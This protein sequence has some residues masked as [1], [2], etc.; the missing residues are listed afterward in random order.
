MSLTA[1]DRLQACHEEL[2]GA[3][4]GHDVEAIQASVARFSE[5]VQEVRALGGWRD[6]PDVK[7]RAA[8]IA[9][10]ADAAQGRVNFLTDLNRHRIDSLDAARGG[11]TGAC[12]GRDGGLT[13]P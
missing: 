3:L 6:N 13:R 11:D 8:H 12:Y 5:A 10:L 7:E 4:D 2:I 1:L 9:R